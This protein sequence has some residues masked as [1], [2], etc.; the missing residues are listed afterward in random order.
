MTGFDSPAD[1]TFNR[2]L[3]ADPAGYARETNAASWLYLCGPEFA[4][5]WVTRGLAELRP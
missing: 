1:L 5:A 2:A 4:E 3:V